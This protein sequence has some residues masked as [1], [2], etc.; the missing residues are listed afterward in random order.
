MMTTTSVYDS[1]IEI[2]HQLEY[3][4]AAELIADSLELVKHQNDSNA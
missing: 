1:V 4:T 3:N 2:A